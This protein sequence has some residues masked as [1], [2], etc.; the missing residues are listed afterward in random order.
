MV[1]LLFTW[2][3]K[4]E[5]LM[6]WHYWL[7]LRHMSTYR[8]RYNNYTCICTYT[9]RLRYRSAYRMS[10]AIQLGLII[11]VWQDKMVWIFPYHATHR[12]LSLSTVALSFCQRTGAVE[13][14]RQ[15]GQMP[16]QY[17]KRT[18][19]SYFTMDFLAKCSCDSDTA[20]PS[21]V[22]PVHEKTQ[23]YSSTAP[24]SK[25]DAHTH[26]RSTFGC[27]AWFEVLFLVTYT[28]YK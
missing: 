14:V 24:T 20:W 12:T 6:W 8:P 11:A 26:I 5:K 27:V 17:L 2:Q 4:K 13:S 15:V 1:L 10:F 28:L 9:M 19:R 3:L 23:L 22:F 7:R 25:L 18:K 21:C 16:N